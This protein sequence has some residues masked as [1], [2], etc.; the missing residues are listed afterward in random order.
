ML[1]FVL[2]KTLKKTKLDLLNIQ[3]N[4]KLIDFC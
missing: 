2:H 4:G 3:I 1:K